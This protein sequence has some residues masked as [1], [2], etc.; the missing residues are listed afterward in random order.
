M[1][2]PQVLVAVSGAI[3][4]DGPMRPAT[5]NLVSGA[6]QF[7]RYAFPPNELGYCGPAGAHV[8]LESGSTGADQA[9]IADRARQFEGAWQYL[10]IIAAAAGI[11]DPLDSRVVEAYWLGNE[12]L[13]R[14]EPGACA[15]QLRER[16][17]GQIT[18]GLDAEPQL[19]AIEAVPQH[20]FHVFTV[21][22]WV[23]M[24]TGERSQPGSG[25]PAGSDAVAVSVLDR[26]R[27]RWG[28]VT[29]V[30]RERLQVLSQPLTWDGRELALGPAQPETVRWTDAG[31]SLLETVHPGQQVALHWDWACDHL[32][33]DQLRMLERYTQR[34]LAATNSWLAAR[35]G[36]A[37]R[38][39]AG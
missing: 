28:E 36:D 24:L 29:E 8:L 22:P 1:T 21:Y 6:A 12:L 5:Q 31:R 26:C 39:G 33:S 34:Q 4:D 7:A 15:E 35:R 38:A 20:S 9:E 19:P 30:E 13:D 27:I 3:G 14:V 10:E 11:D 16:F 25:T 2:G 17:V 37:H 32:D 23:G 18:S